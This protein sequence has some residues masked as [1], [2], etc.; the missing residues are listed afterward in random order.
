MLEENYIHDINRKK[1]LPHLLLYGAISYRV[2]HL[3]YDIGE[4]PPS[5]RPLLY[6][7]EKGHE[8]PPLC[9]K[10][11]R[12]IP[13]SDK[14]EDDLMLFFYYYDP[15]LGT[16]RFFGRLYVKVGSKLMDITPRLNEMAGFA[17]DEELE[18]F[19]LRYACPRYCNRIDK[20]STFQEN[21]FSDG[22]IIYFEKSLKVGSDEGFPYPDILSYKGYLNE[23]A[24][25]Q[26]R[27]RDRLLQKLF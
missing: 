14:T 19:D 6:V 25:P 7:L 13:L 16:F 15:S 12:P 21:E 11:F 26:V 10:D 23:A 4:F 17:V 9:R 5:L 18:Y 2:G 22:N 3:R 27:R 20:K 24:A 1:Y 8:V